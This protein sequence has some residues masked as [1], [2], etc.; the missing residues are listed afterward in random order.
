MIRVRGIY[1]TALTKLLSDMGYSFSDITE[2]TRTRF[3]GELRVVEK[4][5]KV[6]V[7]DRND[8]KGI[9]IIGASKEAGQVTYAI[10]MSIPD[11][12]G[13]LRE[14]G[15]YTSYLVRVLEPRGEYYVVEL[16]GKRRGLLST[17]RKLEPGD[18]VR[19]HVVRA[20]SQPILREGLALFGDYVR[21]VE[22]GRHG[23]SR[24]IRDE[25]KKIELLQ[26]AFRYAPSSWGVRFR[27]AAARASLVDIA[28]EIQ[29]LIEKARHIMEKQV[30]EPMLLSPGESVAEV[31]FTPISGRFLDNIRG[32]HIITMPFHHLFKSLVS[33]EFSG[34]VDFTEKIL[35][36]TTCLDTEKIEESY[37]RVGT[38]KPAVTIHHIKPLGGSFVW[39]ASPKTYGTRIILSRRVSSDGIYDGLNIPRARGDK[40]D[41]F[42]YLGARHVVH[43][44]RTSENSLKG[45]Y[46]NI[47]TPLGVYDSGELWY[48][49]LE[50]DIVALPGKQ[51]TIVDLEEF[52][53]IWEEVIAQP[54]LEKLYREYIDTALRVVNNVGLD[55]ERISSALYMEERRIFS[56]LTF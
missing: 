2:V 31:Y 27:S 51:P 54:A 52:Q 22:G 25:N 37:L 13:I 45:I 26:L 36:Q 17:H 16:P 7:K 11:S 14:E 3:E 49:D 6:T 4:P 48:I 38:S 44:Y 8:L 32:R 30:S 43:E 19:A 50:A 9:V 18:L 24:H 20:A 40:I 12:I 28:A 39:I 15:P 53:K 35:K 34:R 47:N 41:S 21:V 5:P 55:G 1:A 42:T 46:V 56:R 23:V 33:T 29:G 10:V